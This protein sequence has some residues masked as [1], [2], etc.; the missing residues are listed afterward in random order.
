MPQAEQFR[1]PKTALPPASPVPSAPAQR[2]VIA[3]T[4]SRLWLATKLLAASPRKRQRR[5]R[6]RVAHFKFSNFFLIG[7][8]NEKDSVNAAVPRW[9]LR[10]GSERNFAGLHSHQQQR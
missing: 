6:I 1:L 3:L 10:G 9:A 5:S 4:P 2:A 8:E 7:R